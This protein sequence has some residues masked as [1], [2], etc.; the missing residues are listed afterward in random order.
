[1]VW[2]C[3][4]RLHLMRI[5]AGEV[6]PNYNC[7]LWVCLWAMRTQADRACDPNADQTEQIRQQ[8]ASSSSGGPQV[9]TL[10]LV[11]RATELCR[12]VLEDEG[13]AGDLTIS[14]VSSPPYRMCIFA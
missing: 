10:L 4:P 7:I 11:P 8:Q 2:I 1:M 12:K 3:R 14:E 5:I 6:I 9:F 13:V